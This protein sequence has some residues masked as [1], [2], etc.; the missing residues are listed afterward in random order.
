LWRCGADEEA[1]TILDGML[2]AGVF[3]PS[4]LADAM[5]MAARA[6]RGEI[7][8]RLLPEMTAHLGVPEAHRIAGLSVVLALDKDGAGSGSPLAASDRVDLARRARHWLMRTVGTSHRP[9]AGLV[10]ALGRTHEAVGDGD[11]ALALYESAALDLPWDPSARN[12]WAYALAEAGRDLEMAL[13]LVRGARR[14]HGAPMASF[15]DTEAWILHKLGRHPEAS[16]A[17]DQ[18]L[19]H[20]IDAQH[21][22]DEGRVEMMYHQGRILEAVGDEARPRFVFRTCAKR[23]PITPWGKRCADALSTH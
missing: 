13:G 21:M 8:E 2:A 3:T 7:I 17:M 11:A 6:G 9:S 14:D 15:L 12:N 19:L 16:T 20:A 1:R 10:S 18:A 23:G 4:R 5:A 22:A